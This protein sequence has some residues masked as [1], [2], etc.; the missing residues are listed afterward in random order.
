MPKLVTVKVE[1]AISS[2]IN[3]LFLAF[4]ISSLAAVEIERRE[5]VLAF[6]MTGV[7]KPS[8]IATPKAKFTSL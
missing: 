1:P 4:E 6:R 2:G 5:S 3:F 7:N 8:S